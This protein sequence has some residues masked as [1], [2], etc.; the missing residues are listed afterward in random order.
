MTS[1]PVPPSLTP[2]QD[3]P[4]YITGSP[5]TLTLQVVPIELVTPHEAYH[6]RRVSELADRLVADGRLVNP[7]VAVAQ[8]GK[9]IVLDGATRL[10]AFR[11]LGYPHIILQVVDMQKQQ[12]QLHTWYHAVRGGRAENLLH[13]LR[14]VAGLALT[15][16]PVAELQNLAL[17]QGML[18]Y[19]ITADQQ[20]F[21]LEIAQPPQPDQGDWL[22]VLNRM[23]EAYG[24]WG[25]VERTL[26]TDIDLLIGQ[27]PDLAALLIFPEF[28][29]EL[30]LALAAQG[31][32][33][34]AGITRFIIPGRIL[35]LNAPLDKLA[36]DEPLAVKRGW[37]D[38]LVREKLAYRQVR[39]YEEPVV[40]LDE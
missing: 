8:D 29:P 35:R 25:N 38:N 22:D 33:I 28:T 15:P 11:H 1:Q 23:V 30:I 6:G 37:L 7:P 24:L 4:T 10:T 9:Y 2:A 32:A 18:G 27:Y 19:L 21:L 12:V 5:L 13:L 26:T 14:G 3:A 20:G 17:A 40:L 36:A 31:R 34:P 16:K 39:Y